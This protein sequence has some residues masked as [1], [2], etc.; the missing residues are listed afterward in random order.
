[1]Q[2]GDDRA[3]FESDSCHPH[4]A[5]PEERDQ[6][7][8][9]ADRPRLA[10][11]TAGVIDDADGGLVQ[12]VQPGKVTYGCSSSMPVAD[13]HGPRSAIPRGAATESP[14]KTPINPSVR[15]AAER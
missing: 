14:G 4:P 13:P 12:H 9:L 15:K 10:H 7:L 8:R 6:C 5:C 2:P 1:M 3:R 11:D